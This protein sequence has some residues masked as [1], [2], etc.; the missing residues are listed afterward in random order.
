M[1][2]KVRKA[3]FEKL[4]KYIGR[5]AAH[6]VNPSASE[7]LP[8]DPSISLKNGRP[9][10]K[11]TT[12]AA[13][14]AAAADPHCFRVIKDRCYYVSEA[15]LKHTR[16]SSSLSHSTILAAGTCMGKFTKTG[17]FRMHITALHVLARYAKWRVTVKPG[18]GENTFLYGNHILKAH[19]AGIPE[20]IPEH[21]GVVVF[22]AGSSSSGL[23]G[24]ELP[25]GFAVSAKPAVIVPQLEPT[26]IVAFHQSDIG[27][28]IR[29]EEILF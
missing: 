26:A 18:P 27:E 7:I 13:A 14:K 19:I 24:M 11:G 3:F 2:K 20:D 9:A 8:T 1:R 17:K 22:S 29:D 4:S 16:A 21:E 5:N 15:V 6:L 25:L 12:E 23:G 28:Y 10:K